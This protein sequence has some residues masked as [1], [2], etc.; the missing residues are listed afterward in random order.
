VCACVYVRVYVY[1]CSPTHGVSPPPVA[2]LHL[3]SCAVVAGSLR[4]LQEGK[5]PLLHV[6]LVLLLS[7]IAPCVRARV[8]FF[9]R[10]LSGGVRGRE[11][12]AGDCD[13][14]VAKQLGVPRPRQAHQCVHSPHAGDW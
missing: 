6:G 7:S 9:A 3:A 4:H 1:R 2:A 8:S 5:V 12:S 11:W 14:D 10:A 13:R